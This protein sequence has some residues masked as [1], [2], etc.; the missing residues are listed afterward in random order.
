VKPR[1]EHPLALAIMAGAVSAYIVPAPITDFDSHRRVL[2]EKIRA[3]P[4]PGKFGVLNELGIS[5]QSTGRRCGP[6]AS[7]GATRSILRWPQGRRYHR[8]RDPIIPAAAVLLK[9]Y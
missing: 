3:A 7:D 1:S 8:Y 9:E 2:S 5:T 6:T 4:P